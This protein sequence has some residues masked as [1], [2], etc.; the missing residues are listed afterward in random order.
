[1]ITSKGTEMPKSYRGW[2]SLGEKTI[3]YILARMP[4]MYR[5]AEEHRGLPQSVGSTI[6]IIGVAGTLFLLLSCP[7]W[8]LAYAVGYPAMFD[9]VAQWG[10]WLFWL[11]GLGLWIMG[12]GE[13]PKWR[14]ILGLVL[15]STLS[16]FGLYYL[17]TGNRFFQAVFCLFWGT[18]F[19]SHADS[20]RVHGEATRYT[21][22][23]GAWMRAITLTG[24][25][26]FLGLILI[27]PSD[28]VVV[29]PSL[30]L[31]FTWRPAQF[32]FAAYFILTNMIDNASS[33]KPSSPTVPYSPS[34][35]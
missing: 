19:W 7:L 22:Y 8:V 23:S 4:V 10:M 26:Y 34:D 35:R 32:L 1:M 31:V 20:L 29:A 14:V 2:S 30:A 16:L 28:L 15:T 6:V 13:Q 27:M 3:A 12:V 25:S 24:V 11:T 5:S 33:S 9:I 17:G 21:R 18:A